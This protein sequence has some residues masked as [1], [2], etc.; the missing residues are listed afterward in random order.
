MSEYHEQHHSPW[1]D[2]KLNQHV[3]REQKRVQGF[4]EKCFNRDGSIFLQKTIRKKKCSC[5]DGI[6]L[7][8][9]LLP[10]SV[11]IASKSSKT[12]YHAHWVNI[13]YLL[14]RFVRP[15]RLRNISQVTYNQGLRSPKVSVCGSGNWRYWIIQNV[16][17]RHTGICKVLNSSRNII[18]AANIAV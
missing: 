18:I 11:T 3:I 14:Y 8:V 6:W 17:T 5:P 10:W 7:V 9:P 13:I 15:W 16:D 2:Y 4:I 1:R 12:K